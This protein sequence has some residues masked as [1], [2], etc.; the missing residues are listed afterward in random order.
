MTPHTA[1]FPYNLKP[2]TRSR[3][4]TPKKPDNPCASFVQGRRGDPNKLFSL[5]GL[6]GD[7]SDICRQKGSGTTVAFEGSLLIALRVRLGSATAAKPVLL[8]GSPYH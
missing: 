8:K 1:P 3:L 5:E 2:L 7:N 6:H 4:R